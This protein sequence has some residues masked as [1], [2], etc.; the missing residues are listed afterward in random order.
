MEGILAVDFFFARRR[1]RPSRDAHLVT[2]AF[3]CRNFFSQFFFLFQ[4]AKPLNWSSFDVVNK[5]RR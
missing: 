4:V 3:F 1:Q 5:L 2:V